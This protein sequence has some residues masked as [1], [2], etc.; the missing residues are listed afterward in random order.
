[1]SL[2]NQV[3]Y[4]NKL[5]IVKIQHQRHG[6]THRLSGPA[7]IVRVVNNV[8]VGWYVYNTRYQFSEEN[9]L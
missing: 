1:M 7:A 9:I 6:Q 2:K 3:K 4:S 8:N 5:V